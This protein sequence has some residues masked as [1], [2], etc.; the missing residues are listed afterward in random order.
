M[1]ALTRGTP[2]RRGDGIREVQWNVRLPEDGSRAP[3]M[4]ELEDVTA[5]INLAGASINCVHNARNRA[6]IL[7]S[8][9]NTTRALGAA[10]R[11]CAQPPGAWVQA[12][13][14][15]IY[16][17]TT[18]PC[19]ESSALG[20]NF[21]ADVCRQWESAATEECPS[22]VRQVI[23]RIGVTLGRRG[24]AHPKLVQLMK[25][26][27]GGQ[28]GDGRQGMSWIF[29]N[30][31]EEI[32]LRAVEGG[33]MRGVYNACAPEPISNAEFMRVLRRVHERAWQV[34]AP[35]FMIR[36]LAPVFFRTDPGLILEGQFVRPARLLADGFRFRA[37]TTVAALTALS[38]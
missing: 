36:L 8:R 9:L 32:F 10:V 35:A 11:F 6:R 34:P 31:L 15:G 1:V 23:L 4:E 33:E 17:N 13:A 22:S 24:G 21:L 38:D 18:E 19:D 28:A 20:D 30:D 7:D 2:R 3:W 37:P 25:L 27:L 29:I 5:L 26:Y 16:G 14:V 12:S